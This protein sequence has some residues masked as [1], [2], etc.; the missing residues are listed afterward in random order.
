MP[1]FGD[2]ILLTVVPEF[3]SLILLLPSFKPVPMKALPKLTGK[4]VTVWS[5]G[6][7]DNLAEQFTSRVN[8]FLIQSFSG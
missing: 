2:C 1:I 7:V 3:V 5:L 4:N 6:K 8:Y